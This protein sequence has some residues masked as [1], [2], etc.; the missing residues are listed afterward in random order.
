VGGIEATFS[1]FLLLQ[2]KHPLVMLIP[3]SSI[4]RKNTSYR[5]P[6]LWGSISPLGSEFYGFEFRR[7]TTVD[8]ASLIFSKSSRFF[9]IQIAKKSLYVCHAETALAIRRSQKKS[10]H[11]V[12]SWRFRWQQLLET[13]QQEIRNAGNCQRI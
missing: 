6:R 9:K 2:A 5:K 3:E 13:I 1:V 10:K 12:F 8:S 7:N 11:L 4:P